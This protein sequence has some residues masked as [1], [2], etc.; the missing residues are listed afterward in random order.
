MQTELRVCLSP[1]ANARNLRLAW[2]TVEINLNKLLLCRSVHCSTLIYSSLL[3][4][5]QN[6]MRCCV[7]NELRFGSCDVILTF[8]LGWQMFMS[9]TIFCTRLEPFD[10]CNTSS[11]S[12]FSIF[13]FRTAFRKELKSLVEKY[14]SK[15]AAR[16]S[17]FAL[18]ALSL[19]EMAMWSHHDWS[20]KYILRNRALRR[21]LSL[22][23]ALSIAVEL[24]V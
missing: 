10:C 18:L 11:D 8:A 20:F 15:F 14:L 6:A 4:H 2:V 7:Y 5:R 17:Q 23:W 13:D 24:W 3:D 19:Q 12:D 9:Q 22:F 16:F 21:A 1:A